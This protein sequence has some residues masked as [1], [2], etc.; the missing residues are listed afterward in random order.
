MSLAPVFIHVNPW[1][2]FKIQ[3]HISRRI[4][5]F[6]SI[7]ETRARVSL[8]IDSM[9]KWAW[10]VLYLSYGSYNFHWVFNLKRSYF[11][12]SALGHRPKTSEWRWQTYGLRCYFSLSPIPVD[13]IRSYL[14]V[15]RNTKTPLSM[16]IFHTWFT[17]RKQALKW[18]L[19]FTCTSLGESR[20]SSF[21]T[22]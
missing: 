15:C 2:K 12:S 11:F 1:G 13:N 21:Q 6:S 3:R 18:F 8:T 9:S 7:G 22:T 14:N 16:R 19:R 20:S 10:H 17:C 5:N 4:G